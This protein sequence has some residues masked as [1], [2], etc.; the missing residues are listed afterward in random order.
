MN[1]DH[2]RGGISIR[3]LIVLLLQRGSTKCLEGKSFRQS[4]PVRGREVC[5]ALL[6]I[7]VPTLDRI[8]CNVSQG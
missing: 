1:S 3:F 4:K 5:V 8:V 7:T 6:A 2:W